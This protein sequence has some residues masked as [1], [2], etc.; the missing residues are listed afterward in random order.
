MA[1]IYSIPD[2]DYPPMTRLLAVDPGEKNIGLA[3]SDPSG[4]IANPLGILLHTARNLDAAAIAQVARENNVGRIVIGQALD[5]DGEAGPQAR[6]SLRLAEAIRQQTDLP[7]VLWD[8]SGSTFK[9][10][11]AIAAMGVSR[12]KRAGHL[13][14]IAATVILQSY[15]DAHQEK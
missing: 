7:V 4:T 8:E 3:I 12:K 13:D 10:Q 2:H 5:D 14:Q 11:T 9:A 6:K 1:P 15:L